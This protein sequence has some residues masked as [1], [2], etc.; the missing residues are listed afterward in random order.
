MEMGVN[1]AY[2][3]DGLVGRQVPAHLHHLPMQGV[4]FRFQG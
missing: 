2:P 1:G 4:A 3:V